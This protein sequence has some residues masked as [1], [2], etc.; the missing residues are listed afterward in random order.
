M[1]FKIQNSPIKII[2]ILVAALAVTL[3]C[4]CS[5]SRQS[6][7]GSMISADTAYTQSQDTASMQLSCRDRA[8]NAGSLE[9]SDI[10]IE[11]FPPFTPDPSPFHFH[12]SPFTL[13]PYPFNIAATS[14]C[15]T[16]R[17]RAQPPENIKHK[18]ENGKR[19]TG[20]IKSIT[21]GNLKS[22]DS[23]AT[24]T[25]LQLTTE[26]GQQTTDNIQHTTDTKIQN[27]KFKIQDYVRFF[28]ILCLVTG[29][30]AGLYSCHRQK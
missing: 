19:S 3:L 23:T 20:N 29:I 10:R 27:S 7:T 21:I 28:L 17:P 1:K 6:V 12:P 25:D 18:T 24:A 13:K 14:P 2:L 15:D 9:L 26:N 11:F 5:S 8:V 4:S 22:N 16:S 30:F